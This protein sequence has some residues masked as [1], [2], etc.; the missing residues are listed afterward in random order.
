MPRPNRTPG[1]L[2]IHKKYEIMIGP[3]NLKFR[4]FP[5]WDFLKKIKLTREIM[6]TDKTKFISVE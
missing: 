1:A 6:V 2:I 5:F 4:L 3:T